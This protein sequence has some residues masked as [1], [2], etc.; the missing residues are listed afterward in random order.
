[1]GVSPQGRG[2]RKRKSPVVRGQGTPPP[3]VSVVLWCCCLVVPWK[4]IYAIFFQNYFSNTNPVYFSYK[5]SHITNNFTL[6]AVYFSIKSRK[7]PAFVSQISGKK[8][9]KRICLAFMKCY[10]DGEI[11]EIRTAASLF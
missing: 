5:I 3:A 6:K 4:N 1:M 9:H 7:P 11:K 2:E 10:W 8:K